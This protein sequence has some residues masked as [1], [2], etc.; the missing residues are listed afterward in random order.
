M[1]SR[2]AYAG[3]F[4]FAVLTDFSQ[5]DGKIF[6]RARKLRRESHNKRRLLF[7]LFCRNAAFICLGGTKAVCRLRAR[8][9]HFKGNSLVHGARTAHRADAHNAPF[10]PKNASRANCAAFS[11]KTLYFCAGSRYNKA[12]IEKKASRKDASDAALCAQRDPARV[13]GGG[14]RRSGIPFH[15]R[16]ARSDERSSARG[17]LPRYQRGHMFVC[18]GGYKVIVFY[19]K[20][21][22]FFCRKKRLR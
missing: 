11:F 1:G 10:T 6:V 5:T 14:R 16:G 9:C 22:G 18:F 12:I 4:F 19:P 2:S 20:Y 3:G 8:N 21:G 13:R 15:A 7:P 17:V